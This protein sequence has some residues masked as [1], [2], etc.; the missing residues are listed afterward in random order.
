MATELFFEPFFIVLTGKTLCTQDPEHSEE[1]GVMLNV[2][3]PIKSP[4]PTPPT[5]PDDSPTSQPEPSLDFTVEP[6]P[7]PQRFVLPQPIVRPH[8]RLSKRVSF[9]LSKIDCKSA[10]TIY[11]NSCTRD[12]LASISNL[13]HDNIS[14]ANS[15]EN[16]SDMIACMPDSDGDPMSS[17][18]FLP[19]QQHYL[20]IDYLPQLRD[21]SCRDFPNNYYTSCF[22]QNSNELTT[23]SE[24]MRSDVLTH[25]TTDD[26]LVTE[27]IFYPG[28]R[29][30]ICSDLNREV[31]QIID[32]HASWAIRHPTET[33]PTLIRT[34]TPVSS[35]YTDTIHTVHAGAR[36]KQDAACG[37][38]VTDQPLTLSSLPPSKSLYVDT[39]DDQT[40]KEFP[41]MADLGIDH[42]DE[43]HSYRRDV[44]SPQLF[45]STNHLPHRALCRS[46][47]LQVSSP[48]FQYRPQMSQ[49]S[50]DYSTHG[51]NS[52]HTSLQSHPKCHLSRSTSGFSMADCYARARNMRRTITVDC[53][54]AYHGHRM[55][56]NYRSSALDK[57]QRHHSHDY[58]QARNFYPTMSIARC[59][60]RVERSDKF[61]KT[62]MV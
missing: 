41:S 2:H 26:L 35:D 21:A 54:D 22:T 28:L 30:S 33:L 42:K 62:H 59:N 39:E 32:R 31:D 48:H 27:D 5:T 1:E 38:S 14:F 46:S 55:P 10:S 61:K 34:V 56:F 44:T 17:P 3:E 11:T 49:F 12:S 43:P 16:S 29:N 52:R 60:T 36:P 24:D 37:A 58:S 51:Y 23:I 13:Y 40:I 47:S 18:M 6:D 20:P 45:D 15:Y 19:K 4:T 25:R 7:E 9:D 50:F 57:I 53:P 8:N